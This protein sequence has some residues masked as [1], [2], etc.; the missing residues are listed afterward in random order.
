MSGLK[1]RRPRNLGAPRIF[2]PILAAAFFFLLTRCQLNPQET[3]ER[4]FVTVRLNDT[5][6]RLDRVEVV[7]LENG[8]TA[9]VVGTMWDGK[10]P[11]PGAIPSYRLDDAENR[12][13]SIRVEG[14]DA[15]GKLVLDMRISKQDGHQVVANMAI[16]GS[17][18][19]GSNPDT[20]KPVRKSPNL[21]SLKTSAGSLTPPF[22]PETKSYSLSLAYDQ[23]PFT[24]TAQPAFAQ[25]SLLLGNAALSAGAP[26]DPIRPRVGDNG[27]TIT[28]VAGDTSTQYSLTVTRAR[29]V[30][31]VVPPD[32]GTSNPVDLF[33]GWKHMAIVNLDFAGMAI[34]PGETAYGFPLLVR[35]NARNFS[36]SEA[37]SRGK[38]LRVATLSGKLLP[39]E[40]GRWESSTGDAEIWIKVDTLRSDGNNESIALYWGNPQATAA[41]APAVVFARDE[42][43]SGVWHLEETGNGTSGEYKDATGKFNGTGGGPGGAPGRREV[44]V[45]TGQDFKVTNSQAIISLP[46]TYDPG[47]QAWTLQFW[48]KRTGNEEAILFNKAVG[49]DPATQRFQIHDI[50]GGGQKITLQRTGAKYPT[51]V[52]LPQNGLVM[53]GIVYDGSEAIIYMDGFERERANWTQGTGT[54]TKVVLGASD[55]KGNYG[56]SGMMDEFWTS[57]KVRSP[58]FM[59]FQFENQRPGS[60]LATILRIY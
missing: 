20:A 57:S 56:F 40:I 25:A 35:L 7:I 6:S 55:S 39:F 23:S 12:I 36:M 49:G 38:D 21:V 26:S 2:G 27:Y 34:L 37:E 60:K 11:S 50:E 1:P 19:P 29:S 54:S 32:T 16:P 22:D 9:K 15:N 17:N 3:Q 48:V 5:L 30:D 41:S 28:V 10:L 33:L 8:D 47:D 18:P 42:G 52:Y 24:V 51:D 14:F 31:T 43:W 45:G 4:K 44:A 13:L 59:R 58:S 53:L 46:D